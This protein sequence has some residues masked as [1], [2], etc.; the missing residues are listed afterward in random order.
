MARLRKIEARIFHC[1]FLTV[2]RILSN[3]INIRAE[4][5][6]VTMFVIKLS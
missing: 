1:I 6:I 5:V 4:K 3:S 2:V